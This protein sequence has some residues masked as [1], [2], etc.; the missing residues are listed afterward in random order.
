MS[1]AGNRLEGRLAELR[2]AGRRGVAPYL[3]AGDGGLATTVAVLAALEEAGAACV[4][5]GVPFSDPI[6]DGPVLQAAG[7]RAL[8]A[9]TSLGAIL[10]ALAGYRAAGGELPVALMSYANPLLRRGWEAACAAAAA[11]GADALIVPDL[12][13]EESGEMRA[14][15]A[16]A[17]LCPIHFAAPTSPVERLRAAAAASRGFLYVVGRTG[18]T[19]SGTTFDAATRAFLARVAALSP[20]PTAVGFGIRSAADVRAAVAHADLAIVGS[21]MVERLHAAGPAAAPAA[22]AA[23]LAELQEGLR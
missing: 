4:E 7:E 18:V 19:G 21:A 2:A 12:P 13:L 15:A 6:A 5:L 22:A 9:G 11:A 23:F 14:A 3:T 10:D 17:G 1:G 20:I 8:A 16:A